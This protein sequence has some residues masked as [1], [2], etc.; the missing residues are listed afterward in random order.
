MTQS[1][2][3]GEAASFPLPEPLDIIVKG[4]EDF[5]V[6]FGCPKCGQL[7]IL[8]KD[9]DAAERTTKRHEAAA[10][11]VKHCVC[12]KSLDY[13]YMLRCKDCRARREH[14][15]ELARFEK[16]QKLTLEAYDGPVY[17]EGHV[18]GYGEGYFSGV[19]EI[20]DYCE[21]EGI[22]VPAYVWACS[23]K[24]FKLD[25]DVFIERELESQEMFEE[26]GERISEDARARLQSYLNVWTGEQGLVGWNADQTRAVLL[27]EEPAALSAE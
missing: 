25:A 7:F 20:L 23:P 21:T 13:H 3:V 1:A 14:E 26:A 11:C 24:E 5:T 9:D 22:E 12:G 27:R 16:A 18:G 17:W 4:R 19:D 6:A 10:H 15:K 2:S 8:H